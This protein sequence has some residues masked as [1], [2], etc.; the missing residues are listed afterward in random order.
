MRLHKA[1]VGDKIK[2]LHSQ[3]PI[4]Q[5]NKSRKNYSDIGRYD[6]DVYVYSTSK[7]AR[8]NTGH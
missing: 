3:L 6:D 2:F 7:G 4:D 5:W 8:F 1:I